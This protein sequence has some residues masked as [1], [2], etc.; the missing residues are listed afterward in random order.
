MERILTDVL[1][2][3]AWLLVA[4]LLAFCGGYVAIRVLRF[5]VSVVRKRLFTATGAALLALALGLLP[6]IAKRSGT[7]GVSPVAS[8]TTGTTGV[9]PVEN[10]A[11]STLHLSAITV[12]S[13]GT[14]T[15]TAAWQENLL[16]VGQTLDVLG[17]ENIRD[18]TWTWLTNGVATIGATNV[19]WTLENQSSSNHFYKVVVRDTFTDM[20]DPDCDGV[21]NVYELHHGTNPWVA[22]ASLVPRLTVGPEGTFATIAAAVAESEDYS[23]IELDPSVR[24]DLTDYL[25]VQIPQHPI[26][27]TTTNAYA[28]VRATGMAAFMLPTN[29]TSRTLF[30]NIY[31]LLGR[32]EGAQSGFWCGG[33]LPWA[34]VSASATFENVYVRMPNP[35]VEYRGWQ[36]YRSNAQRLL[37]H[38]CTL[39]A[40]GATWA[41]GVDAFGAPPLEIDGCS[42]VNFPPDGASGTGCGILLRTSGLSDGGSDVTVSRT[43]FDES[44]TNA[45]PLGRFDASDPYSASFSD[46]LLP[47]AFPLNYPPDV[48]TDITV[49]NAALA[50]CGVP[51]ADSPSVV[52]G[53][54]SLAPIGTDPTIDTDGDTLPDYTEAYELGTDP[55]LADSD[56]DGIPDVVEISEDGTDAANPHSFK[57]RLT[58]SVTNTASL[59]YA[60]YTAWGYSGTGWETNGLASFSHG[61]GET[62]YT[63]ASAQGATH[64]KAYCDLNANGEY[65]ANVDIFLMREIPAGSTA[66]INISFGDVDGDGVIDAQER[67][68]GT[69]PY[70]AKSFRLVATVLFT[71]ADVKERITNHVAFAQMA[72]TWASGRNVTRFTGRSYALS[73]DTN[74]TD[75]VLR[76][77]CLRDFDGDGGYDSAHDILYEKVLDKSING[78]SVAYSLGD[79]DHDGVSDSEEMTEGTNPI[80]PAN[81][82]FSL[83]ARF[84]GIFSTTNQ[85]SAEVFFGTNRMEGPIVMS[86]RTWYYETGHLVSSNRETVT[87]YLWDDA[88]LN[89]MRDVFETAITN[90]FYI[91]GHDMA[92][93]NQLAYGAFDADDDEMLDYWEVQHG[94]S[95][96][97]AADAVFDADGDGFANLYEF[98]AGTDPN[99]L[100]DDG[101]GTALYAICHGVDDR[102]TIATLAA[103]AKSNYVNFSRYQLPE[104]LYVN[105]ESWA[106]G[107]DF[108]CT[109]VWNDSTNYQYG[110][111]ATLLS[112]QHVLLAKHV[113]SPIGRCYTFQDTNGFRCVRTLVATQGI[114]RTDIEIGLLDNALPSSFVPAKLLPVGYEQYLGSGTFLPVLHMDQERKSLVQELPRLPSFDRRYIEI[115]CNR[116]HTPRRLEFYEALVGG[117][118]GSPCFLLLGNQRVL[119]Y[120][121]QGHQPSNFYASA[122]YHT[123]RFGTEIQEAM[124]NLSAAGGFP[125][126]ILQ[127]V[128]LSGYLSLEN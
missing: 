100:F 80:N 44:F 107:I 36:I 7:T 121:V 95:P 15:L 81:Y 75:G 73:I 5:L 69:D 34:G 43:L 77:M 108:S 58:V 94:F 14:V 79:Y 128:D 119:I 50:W 90:R 64:V 105:P 104:T 89:G 102:I 71:D 116:G 12:S 61:F 65:D 118:S 110:D 112:P 93:T 25:G 115:F 47:R 18:E 120:A 63:N 13:N 42:F 6:T 16:V 99:D 1:H 66:Q 24:H 122:G 54:G 96:T 68:D 67:V 39:N 27:L 88:N 37:L 49:T 23:V 17:K 32:E 97:N 125:L 41:V 28:V 57:Q 83:S 114:D 52:L 109:P 103:I 72:G 113:R 55:W 33:N 26:L 35:G 84:T 45:W 76:V 59:A 51:F 40:S 31:L 2:I 127:S 9:S 29:T 10:P 85:L 60:A 21:P 70:D 4:P 87:V 123:M 56:N 48:A 126:Y 62:V 8:G 74:L 22:D 82:C 111:P 78:K 98:W 11:A 124:D 101:Y 3:V 19:S 117:D 20:D 86:E 92:V 53:V 46:C 38:N 106:T 91:T 30:R